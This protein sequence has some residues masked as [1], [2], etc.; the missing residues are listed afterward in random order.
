ME[1]KTVSFVVQGFSTL[2]NIDY[3]GDRILK[4]AAFAGVNRYML[5]AAFLGS[6]IIVA[7]G[8]LKLG[9]FH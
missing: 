2:T 1:A 5:L 4:P 8:W 9:D 7:I 6:F 3:H